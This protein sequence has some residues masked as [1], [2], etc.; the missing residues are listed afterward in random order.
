MSQ[1]NH[2]VRVA[3]NLKGG[4]EAEL[5]QRTLIVGPNGSG[6][7]AIINA[8]ELALTGKASDIAGRDLVSQGAAL[9]SLANGSGAWSEVSLNDGSTARWEIARKG[10]SVSRAKRTGAE[11]ILPLR[12]VLDELTG[13]AEKARKFLLQHACEGLDNTHITSKLSEDTLSRYQRLTDVRLAPIDNLL[14]VAAL[15]GKKERE[16]KK[17]TAGA[18]EAEE[19]AAA[20]LGPEPDNMQLEEAR[21][22]RE[23]AATNLQD[24]KMRLAQSQVFQRDDMLS[25]GERHL[26]IKG[27]KEWIQKASLEAAELH[28]RLK[29][30][31]ADEKE[32]HRQT[33]MAVVNLMET[34]WTEGPCLACGQ[35][36]DRVRWVD[37]ANHIRAAVAAGEAKNKAR[38]DERRTAQARRVELDGLVRRASAKIDE[39]EKMPPLRETIDVEEVKLECEAAAL[40][41]T[42]A[43]ETYTTLREQSACWERVRRAKAV[44]RNAAREALGWG[45]LD[46]A[47]KALVAE[48]VEEAV[49]TFTNRVQRFLPDG[50]RF[51]IKFDKSSVRY[52]LLREGE[53]HTALSGAEWARVSTAL[54]AACTPSEATVPI[55]VPE[56]RAWDAK[57]LRSVLQGLSDYRGQ[58]I[59][60]TTIKPFRGVPAGWSMLEVGE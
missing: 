33:L 11:G 7:S 25:V 46:A 21:L 9:A 4:G 57:T 34:A 31:P 50:E 28:D 56:D 39:V 42:R 23:D 36:F 43:D 48:L 49:G 58:V 44:R 1:V 24:A 10:R 51:S 6:K 22:A 47:C 38:A 20:G 32:G 5:S 8:V 52:G 37:H 2:V 16:V 15:A 3:H 13:S 30:I 53:I 19:A 60:A 59:V 29:S 12:R 18:R 45:M 54:A 41:V 27:L 14:A 35:D 40:E 17:H 55:L 26:K